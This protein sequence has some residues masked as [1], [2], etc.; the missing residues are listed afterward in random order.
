MRYPGI[1]LHCHHQVTGL[2]ASNVE[3]AI[4]YY[5]WTLGFLNSHAHT[6]AAVLRG[7]LYTPELQVGDRPIH[8]SNKPTIEPTNNQAVHQ[9]IHPSIDC[10]P[11]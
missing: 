10:N 4:A 5:D 11:P 6:T 7:G 1:L 8:P 2:L 9:T 3:P